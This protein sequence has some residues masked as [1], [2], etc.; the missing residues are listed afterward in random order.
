MHS[1]EGKDRG[2]ERKK[3]RKWK[4]VWT[5]GLEEEDH[6]KIILYVSFV[7]AMGIFFYR[8]KDNYLASAV[9]QN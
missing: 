7:S 1:L 8:K 3:K 5:D 2:D 4:R 6:K 9:P